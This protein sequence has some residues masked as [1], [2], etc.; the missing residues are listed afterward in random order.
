MNG[1][2]QP[3]PCLHG[4]K[5]QEICDPKD[6]RFRCFC[7][8]NY[9]GKRCEIRCYESCLKA[10]KADAN[11]SG[12]FAICDGKS[13][14]FNVYCDMESESKFVWTLFQS[15]SFYHSKFLENK[16]F[17]VNF[18]IGVN[19]TYIDWNYYRLPLSHMTYI[20]QKSSHLRVTCNFNENGLQ[21][22][23]Y[24]RT[25][26]KNQP[27]LSNFEKSCKWYGYLNIR[28]IDCTSCTALTSQRDGRPWFID[29][30]SSK[31]NG[32][33]FNGK[34]GMGSSEHNFGWYQDGKVNPSHRCSFSPSSTT[35]HWFGSKK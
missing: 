5:C 34:P 23:D 26:L 4:G 12:I 6:K 18:P 33:Q 29:S 2:C 32:C 21:Y 24:A 31:G 15:F 1:C 3:N 28:G 9:I 19:L 13:T 16:G 22:T 7:P 27:I 11:K 8:V 10:S 35:E 14:A 20:K 25:V 30:Y 17:G